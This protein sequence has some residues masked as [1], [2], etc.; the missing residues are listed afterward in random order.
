MGISQ[1]SLDAMRGA[2]RAMVR[3]GIHRIRRARAACRVRAYRVACRAVDGICGRLLA[4]RFSRR[5]A[6]LALRHGMGRE[7]A[8]ALLNDRDAQVARL[9]AIADDLARRCE[10]GRHATAREAS[11]LLAS[12]LAA[13]EIPSR[14]HRLRFRYAS[15]G[16]Y[17]E[18]LS[19]RSRK[20][21]LGFEAPEALV[22]SKVVGR[23]FVEALGYPVPR[24]YGTF[25][26][27]ELPD[28]GRMAIKPL[29]EASARGVFLILAPDRIYDVSRSEWITAPDTLRSRMQRDLD[30]GRVGA[31]AWTAE[32]LVGCE[33][34]EELLPTN[35][36]F[37]CFYGRVPLILEVA[38]GTERRYCWWTPDGRK[39]DT[40]KH[41]D[42][43]FDG[44]GVRDD[45]LQVARRISLAIPAPFVRI[46]F[47]KTSRQTLFCEFTPLPG[48]YESFDER[49]DRALGDA[50]LAAE[51]R[52][53]RDLL[54]GR[55]F[56]TFWRVV[57]GTLPSG[58]EPGDE[59]TC[60][61]GGRDDR[62]AAYACGV[63]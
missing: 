57:R 63:G 38:A 3:R 1:A 4:W 6:D 59:T 44:H 19:L 18:Q 13:S 16:S 51:G 24:S 9:R 8:D 32:Q 27:T 40:G 43:L 30:T 60:L 58:S 33:P 35:L 26:H 28:C 52:L 46:D 22:D 48:G 17:R 37:F 42:R 61:D 5:S 12:R 29:D 14:Y 41:A 39:I 50:F 10:R 55:R 62:R 34:P 53:E 20:R 23:S 56:D 45:Q 31:D 11:A 7:F 36:K 54:A 2:P 21:Q 47:L 25:A 15:A 49:T